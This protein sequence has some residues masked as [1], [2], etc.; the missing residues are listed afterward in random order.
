MYCARI[1]KLLDA[2]V[3]PEELVDKAQPLTTIN[4]GY[5]QYQ[6]RNPVSAADE[7]YWPVILRRFGGTRL[8]TVD[9]NWVEITIERYKEELAPSTIRH[10]IGALARLW[11]WLLKKQAVATNPFRILRRGYA[12]GGVKK[13]TERDRRIEHDEEVRLICELDGDLLTIFVLAL[14]TAM[15]MS[16]IYTLTT[17]QINLPK[18]TIFLDK[19]KNGDKRQVP[20][21]STALAILEGLPKKGLAFPTLWDGVELRRKATSRSSTAFGRAA[22]RAAC[23]DITFHDTRHE[24]TCRLY[25]RTKLSDLQIAKITGHKDLRMLMRYA[26]LRGSSLAEG[27]W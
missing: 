15:R 2:G 25:E 26:N 7:S 19:T 10:H 16:E 21:S 24:A 4:Q 14:E 13:D 27:L 8:T 18:R 20:L 3:V 1:E 11:D 17:D 9:Y 22:D 12:T 6:K 5:E 23:G